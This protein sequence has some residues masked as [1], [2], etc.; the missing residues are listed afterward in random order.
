MRIDFTL[1]SLRTTE[2]TDASVL[3]QNDLIVEYSDDNIP[4]TRFTQ[5]RNSMEISVCRAQRLYNNKLWPN[6]VVVRL[7]N[8]QLVD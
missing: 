7:K 4:E 5:R 6:P 8:V 1:K 2:A 3:G